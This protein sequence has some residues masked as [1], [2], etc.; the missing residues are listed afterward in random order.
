MPLIDE[1]I[2]S[3]SIK[4]RF[5]KFVLLAQVMNGMD[6]KDLT[7]GYQLNSWTPKAM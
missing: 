1:F 6:V 5:G 4:I 2:T 3:I 7:C